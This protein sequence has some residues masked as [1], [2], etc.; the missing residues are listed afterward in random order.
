MTI[1]RGAGFHMRLSE[2]QQRFKDGLIS[3][4]ADAADDERLTDLFETGNIPFSGRF[5]VYRDNL[6]N[7]L[8]RVLCGTFPAVEALVGE[9]FMKTVCHAYIKDNLPK[10]GNLNLYGAGFPAFLQSF[11]AAQ[12]VPYLPDVA[13]LE[14]AKNAAYHAEDDVALTPHGLQ[15][16]SNR[17]GDNLALSLRASC[18][19]LA[20]DWP[21][22]SIL[23][24]TQDEGGN[25]TL[26]L[27]RP[28]EKL[29]VYRPEFEVRLRPLDDA[30]FKFLE[31]VSGSAP[32][33]E[34]IESFTVV[35]PKSDVSSLLAGFINEGV[36]SCPSGDLQA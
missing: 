26:S 10:A 15:E 19:L 33:P 31:L 27:D 11:P 23:K 7:S 35:Y 13:R 5:A 9:G 12:S 36:L 18:S 14:W 6:F 21:V 25:D 4:A 2:I 34:V 17:D 29:L 28:G 30:G 1:H 8:T 24:F 20:S 16:I 3:P 22:M 32:L